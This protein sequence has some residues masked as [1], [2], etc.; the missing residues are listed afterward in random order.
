MSVSSTQKR[1]A[2]SAA[3][4]ADAEPPRLLSTPSHWLTL[5]IVLAAIIAFFLIAGEDWRI[6]DET[7]WALL[8]RFPEW[9]S[10][11]D[12]GR[13]NQGISMVIF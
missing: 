1:T 13:G 12:L 6:S 5:A 9:K 11:S 8:K 4:L 7:T 3:N 2:A 10:D